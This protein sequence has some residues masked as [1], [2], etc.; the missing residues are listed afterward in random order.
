[1][2]EC[3]IRRLKEAARVRKSGTTRRWRDGR[4]GKAKRGNQELLMCREIAGRPTERR[5]E[6]AAGKEG[7]KLKRVGRQEG[8]ELGRI[9]VGA[10]NEKKEMAKWPVIWR[11]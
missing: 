1:M 7:W 9:A 4:D 2:V 3:G 8:E 6:G 5:A 10:E 11:T